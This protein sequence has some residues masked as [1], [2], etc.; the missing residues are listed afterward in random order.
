MSMAVFAGPSISHRELGAMTDARIVGPIK[1]GDLEKFSDIDT[2]VILDG[3][4]GQ[5]LSVS[6]KEI[7]PLLEQGKSVIGASSMGALRAS[8]LD[9]DGMLGIGWVYERFARAAV[10]RDDEVALTYSPIDF[11]AT[12]VPQVNIEY[13][14]ELLAHRNRISAGERARISRA[15]RAIFFAERTEERVRSLLRNILGSKRLSRL[16]KETGGTIPDI[17]FIDAKSAVLA[18]IEIES[19]RGHSV[20]GKTFNH[21]G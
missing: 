16:L 20:N 8:E 9:G 13:F 19:R 18:A 21:G 2:V 15:S 17:K 10:R 11:K 14:L 7:L 4:F 6:P 12:T 5:N 3:E 1:R